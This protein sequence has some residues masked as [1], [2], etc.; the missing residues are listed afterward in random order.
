MAVATTKPRAYPENACVTIACV[1]KIRDPLAHGGATC[2]R[3]PHL[4]RRAYTCA[5]IIAPSDDVVTTLSSTM[6][7]M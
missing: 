3:Q 4:F 7:S 6:T 1:S 2:R 5:A